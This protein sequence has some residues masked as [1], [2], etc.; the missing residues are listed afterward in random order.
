M[1]FDFASPLDMGRITSKYM[2]V[3]YEDVEDKTC[4]HPH[5]IVMLNRK[6]NSNA[7][8]K[9]VWYYISEFETEFFTFQYLVFV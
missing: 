9:D 1:R 8:C 6:Y 7:S 2:R 3:E 5:P 4:P